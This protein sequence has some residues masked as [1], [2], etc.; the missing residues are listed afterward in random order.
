MKKILWLATNQNPNFGGL[1]LHSINFVKAL[2]QRGFDIALCVSK[3]SYVD[4]NTD[5]EKYYTTTR[6]S[7]D[8]KALKD[9]YS[10]A[11]DF[12]PDIIVCN[13]AKEYEISLIVSR[14]LRKKVIAFRHMENLK[15]PLVS[16]FILS[17]MDLVYVVSHKLSE[18]LML[19][20]VKRQKLK[21]LYNLIREG[22]PKK[23]IKDEIV[24][25][26]V[27]KITP[28]KGIW[29]FMHLAKYLKDQKEFKFVVVGDGDS[30]DEVKS[31]S[32][33]HGLNVDFVGFQKD[34]YPFYQKADV[35]YVLSKYDEAISRVAI[36]GLA[37]G[38]AVVGSKIGGIKETIE[39]GLNGF[40]VNP[41]DI[42]ALKDITLIFK[43]KIFLSKAQRRSFEIYQE[44]FLEKAMIDAFEKDIIYL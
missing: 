25:L 19:K 4:K 23:E 42:D 43:D 15:N 31:F 22:N 3:D 21:V 14:L 33:K 6:Y 34:V 1:E 35:V 12:N 41:E 5:V 37:N 40:L 18:D 9:L 38:C 10:Y 39:E 7:F 29:E 17:N 30:L 13:N 32:K 11:K 36:E 44:R 28:S 20:G 2:A 24:C 8:L 16:K 26:F 27:G